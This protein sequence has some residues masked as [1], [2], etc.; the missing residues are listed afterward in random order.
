M[1]VVSAH[2]TAG[3]DSHP[4]TGGNIDHVIA[5][6]FDRDSSKYSWVCVN[7]RRWVNFFWGALKLSHTNTTT[8]GDRDWGAA[9]ED[10]MLHW[11]MPFPVL[12][13][14]LQSFPPWLFSPTNFLNDRIDW[15][16]G[17]QT[18][19]AWMRAPQSSP[20]SFFLKRGLRHHDAS[21]SAKCNARRPNAASVTDLSLKSPV[22]Q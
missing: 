14:G 12:F 20:A 8:T 6:H 9:R 1:P 3:A 4:S 22:G 21:A 17:R 2:R 5:L 15:I 13:P 16:S 11:A 7:E 10:R 18:N 19:S